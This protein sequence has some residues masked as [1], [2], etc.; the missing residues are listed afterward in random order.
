M[1][2]NIF[3]IYLHKL[4]K[5]CTDVQLKWQ[6]LKVMVCFLQDVCVH[7]AEIEC[8]FIILLQILANVF[9]PRSVV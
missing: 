2:S 9:F 6:W 7:I 5:T 4:R 8:L 3:V 1:Y